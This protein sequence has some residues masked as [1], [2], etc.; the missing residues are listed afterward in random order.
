MGSGAAVLK[1]KPDRR[2]LEA[3]AEAT[4]SRAGLEW[5]Q[6]ADARAARLEARLDAVEQEQDEHREML[7]VHADWDRAMVRRVSEET[8]IDLP[9]PPPLFLPKRVNSRDI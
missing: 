6:R 5:T 8:G 1:F 7:H 9:A 2:K 4:L 3:E